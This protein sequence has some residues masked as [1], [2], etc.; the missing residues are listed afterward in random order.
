[1]AGSYEAEL[2][3][4]LA[5]E[6]HEGEG[7]LEWESHEAGAEGEGILGAIGNALGGLLGE[8]EEEAHEYEAHELHE[9]RELHELESE[10]EE[11][12]EWESHES[13]GEGEGLLGSLLGEGE[14]EAHEYE[15]HE[16]H[17]LHELH[18]GAHEAG[19]QFFGKIARGIGRIVRRA[20]PLLKRI[21][22][23]AA[24]MV[25]TAIGGPF[26]AILGKVASSAL[27]E[28]ELHEAHEAHEF[29]VEGE[30]EY[31]AHEA[32]HEVAHEIAYHETTQHEALAELMAEAAAMEHHEAEAEA[33]AGA[34]VMTTVSPG[35]RRALRRILPHL[36]RGVAILTRI[37]RRRRATRPAVRAIPTIVRRT[38]TTLKRQAAAGTPI[39]RRA[40]GR[41]AA[42]QVRRVLGNPA[43]CTAAI[44]QNVRANRVLRSRRSSARP[45]AG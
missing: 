6:L 22:K 25:G 11:E 2:E 43:A 1:M 18:E 12:L 8:G 32:S 44:A 36:V 23:V 17:E 27:G 7:E 10:S 3:R 45:V 29:E 31:E 28:G 20:A 41:A 24:P 4:E 39:T 33:M 5:H 26:G 38:V 34:A 42:V 14:E 13:S 15:A 21:A 37:L 30:G 19:E 9:A 16:A 40:A 35:D